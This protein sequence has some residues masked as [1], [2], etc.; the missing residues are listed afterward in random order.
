MKALLPQ[1]SRQFS[2]EISKLTKREQDEM[3]YSAEAYFPHARRKSKCIGDYKLVR[4]LVTRGWDEEWLVQSLTGAFLLAEV[5]R[6]SRFT[7]TK[8]YEM[9]FDSLKLYQPISHSHENL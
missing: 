5:V 7:I 9:A 3:E 2:R 1:D 4:R 8:A 6:R